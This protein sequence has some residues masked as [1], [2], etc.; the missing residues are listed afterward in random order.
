ML[1]HPNMD[2]LSTRN[3]NLMKDKNYLIIL[4]DCD[5]NNRKGWCSRQNVDINKT[6]FFNDYDDLNKALIELYGPKPSLQSVS[7]QNTN[8]YDL[9]DF[10][11]QGEEN[12]KDSDPEIVPEEC[13][14]NEQHSN[15]SLRHTVLEV[16]QD[17]FTEHLKM[18]KNLTENKTSNAGLSHTTSLSSGLE[19]R[20]HH[21]EAI[22]ISPEL[23]KS[24]EASSKQDS[25]DSPKSM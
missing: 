4:L 21:D 20:Q 5:T 9:K 12:P 14:A 1:T 13:K 25:I 22:Q 23:I 8:L 24:F 6:I 15:T 10:P 11:P 3:Y 2:L 16:M 18:I 17:I 7:Y 19:L